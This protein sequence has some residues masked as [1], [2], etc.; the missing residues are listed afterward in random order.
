MGEILLFNFWL[1]A[2]TFSIF[3]DNER[4]SSI[5]FLMKMGELLLFIFF[6]NKNNSSIYYFSY[7]FLFHRFILLS[8]IRSSRFFYILYLPSNLSYFLL[9]M[10]LQ[11][12]AIFHN[13]FQIYL[14]FSSI[15]DLAGIFHIP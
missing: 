1:M 4:A 12:F 3:F 7:F 5:Y 14:A 6:N 2:R 11:A 10:I 15:Y 9:Y 13:F 8:Y